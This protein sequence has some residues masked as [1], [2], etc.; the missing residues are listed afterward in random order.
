M[1]FL[2]VVIDNPN[3]EDEDIKTLFPDDEDVKLFKE[4]TIDIF[5]LLVMM[6]SFQ[7]KG[8]A[9]KNWAGPKEIPFGFS[10][11][12]VGKL[13]RHLTIWNPQLSVRNNKSFKSSLEQNM[14]SG[15]IE[16]S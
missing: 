14:I 13:K 4:G 1:D 12:I 11:F 6:G 7:S 15:V 3:F 9:K 10:E 2:N 8:Q 16:N 5:D